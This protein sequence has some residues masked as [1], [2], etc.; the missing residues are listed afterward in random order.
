MMGGVRGARRSPLTFPP[1]PL[2][3]LRR[4]PPPSSFHCLLYI[5]PPSGHLH[6]RHRI[7]PCVQLLPR[8]LEA[9]RLP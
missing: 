1:L 3:H 2:F 6:R 7:D 4:P 8:H 5:S 9:P